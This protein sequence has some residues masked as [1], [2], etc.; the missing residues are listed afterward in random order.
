MYTLQELKQMNSSTYNPDRIRLPHVS[1]SQDTKFQI[2]PTWNADL[3]G[4]Y[5]AAIRA[6][7]I[8]TST[9]KEKYNLM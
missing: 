3:N 7:R 5:Y 6:D 8:I 1:Y 2:Y 4:R 9:L